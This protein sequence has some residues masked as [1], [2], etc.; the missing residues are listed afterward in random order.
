MFVYLLAL[1]YT[2]YRS[3]QLITLSVL[4]TIIKT[5]CFFLF[6]VIPAVELRSGISGGGESR[7]NLPVS[8]VDGTDQ[9][10]KRTSNGE[11]ESLD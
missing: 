1:V 2:V 11:L 9:V 7:G 5:V 10:C 4:Y 6:L 3:T 8:G